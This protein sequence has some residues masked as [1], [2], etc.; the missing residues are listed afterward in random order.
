MYMYV[1]I[2]II[3]AHIHIYMYICI[4]N[5]MDIYLNHDDNILFQMLMEHMLKTSY[6]LDHA[7]KHTSRVSKESVSQKQAL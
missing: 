2:Y 4:M 5:L 1:S 6:I 3:H 7:K